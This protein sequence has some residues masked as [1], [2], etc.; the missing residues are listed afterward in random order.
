MCP[1]LEIPHPASPAKDY[2]AIRLNY[3]KLLILDNF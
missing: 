2:F 1:H 3:V